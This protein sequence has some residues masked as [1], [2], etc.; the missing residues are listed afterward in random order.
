[1]ILLPVAMLADD[2]IVLNNGDIVRSKVIEIGQHEIKYKKASNPDGPTYSMD[3]SEVFS[4]TYEN[5]EKEILYTERPAISH[6]NSNSPTFIE[7]VPDENNNNLIAY[8]NSSILKHK[9]KVPNEKKS[10]LRTM[11]LLI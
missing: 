4:I 5:G 3:K 6:K 2:I 8:Y 1:M 7:A 10:N 11:Q 9:N